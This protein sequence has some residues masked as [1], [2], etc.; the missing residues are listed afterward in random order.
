MYQ[1]IFCDI[2]GTLRNNKKEVAEE[3]KEMIRKVQK[4]GIEFIITSGRPRCETEEVARQCCASNYII[5]SNGAEAYDCEK[6]SIIYQNP[7]KLEKL[8][9]LNEIANYYDV[10]LVMNSGNNRVVNKIK[11][12]GRKELLPEEG[13]IA[14]AQKH[15]VVQCVL[16][17]KDPMKMKKVREEILLIPEVKIINES[18]YFRTGQ[19]I[20][21]DTIYCDVADESTSKGNCV[22]EFCK[23]RQIP[24]QKAIA[25]GDSYND[26]SM[27]KIVG[28]GVVM[29][30]ADTKIKEQVEVITKSNEENGVAY[31]LE[32]LLKG[33]FEK[34]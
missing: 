23:R 4:K 3:T 24:L 32:K 22:M 8:E 10:V 12:N 29:E 18:D 1:V 25:I 16:L 34:C 33:E 2:D 6:E 27:L 15:D 7:M 20:E 19:V 21:N 9:R 30:N 14:Y 28:L 26:L 5:D 13:I 31:F 11:K 17:E